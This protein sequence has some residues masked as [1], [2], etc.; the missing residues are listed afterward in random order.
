MQEDRIQGFEVGADDY[1]T[2]PFSMEEL[3]MRIKAIMRRSNASADDKRNQSSSLE[4]TFLNITDN[5]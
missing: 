1:L 3:L 5:Y 2:K 4:N